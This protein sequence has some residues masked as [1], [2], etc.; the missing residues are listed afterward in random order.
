[1][2]L[3]SSTYNPS[4]FFKNKHIN[5]V[6]RTLF[7]NVNVNYKRK[8]FE[9]NDNDFI[10]VDFISKNSKELI[11]AIHG[12]EGSSDSSY[13]KSIAQYSQKL[14][15]DFACMNLRGCSG[16]LNNQFS[17]YHSGKTE[18]LI[19]IIN[20]L[21]E[22]YTSIHLLG[23][24][25]GANLILKYLGETQPSCCIKKAVAISVPLDLT[26]TSYQLSE[27]SNFIYLNRFM[28]SLK[29]KAIQKGITH[30]KKSF[31]EKI[32][33]AS[34]FIDFD[35]LYT[36]PAHG[37]KDAHE[38]WDINSSKYYVEKI[39]TPTLIINAK[40]DPFFREASFPYS[41][42]KNLPQVYLERPKHGGHVGFNSSEK[43]WLEKRILNFFF[44]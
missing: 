35:N 28:K 9:T 41:M 4:F 29:A 26:S 13:I 36:A 7:S 11:L 17:S 31:V 21:K 25:L 23:Y 18:D 16:E 42:I 20:Q 19:F 43:N 24:S 22:Q 14:N 10:D 27:K 8:R 1:M 30:N 40:D 44:E 39:T 15:I 6:Y 12:L 2:P 3:I 38:Y 5:T 33:T 32:K 37:F 34:N